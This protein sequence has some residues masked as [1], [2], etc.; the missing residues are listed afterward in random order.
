MFT[1]Q[2]TLLQVVTY[3]LLPALS[4]L[5]GAWAGARTT[6][7]RFKSERTFDRVLDWLERSIRGLA[8]YEAAF[9]EFSDDVNLGNSHTFLRHLEKSISLNRD[10]IASLYEA[11]VL[12]NKRASALAQTIRKRL[13]D[14]PEPEPS[15][16]PSPNMTIEMEARVTVSKAITLL[17]G[18]QSELQEYRNVLECDLRL[19]LNLPSEK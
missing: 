2:V 11:D 19:H 3:L 5:L 16:E 17:K 18:L 12:G 15:I 1:E 7:G 6:F 10:L 9:K 13:Q 8:T 4:A 14:I